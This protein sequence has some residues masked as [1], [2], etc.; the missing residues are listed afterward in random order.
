L[1]IH[2]NKPRYINNSSSSN[3]AVSW[4][5][6]SWAIVALLL[7]NC[8]SERIGVILTRRQSECIMQESHNFLKFYF[9]KQ[10]NGSAS[11]RYSIF[12]SLFSMLIGFLL[13]S[14]TYYC[15][16]SCKKVGSE[17]NTM[18]SSIEWHRFRAEWYFSRKHRKMIR[19]QRVI[20]HIFFPFVSIL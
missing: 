10:F 14:I 11:I 15:R 8:N 19:C 2:K 9:A 4:I 20:N 7:L 5:I 12:D 16:T 17:T 1:V 3:T 18:N 6:I 13:M